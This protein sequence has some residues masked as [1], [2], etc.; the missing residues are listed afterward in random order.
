M[1]KKGM[2][3]TWGQGYHLQMLSTQDRDDGS[4]GGR[5]RGEDL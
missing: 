2:V 5:A 1:E 3:P 4:Q